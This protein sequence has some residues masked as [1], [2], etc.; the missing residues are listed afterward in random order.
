[1]TTQY[2][3]RPSRVATDKENTPVLSFPTKGLNSSLA[4]IKVMDTT[5]HSS[6]S[7]AV[8]RASKSKKSTIGSLGI[9]RAPKFVSQR[10]MS[11]KPYSRATSIQRAKKAANKACKAKNK[12]TYEKNKGKGRIARVEEE[13]GLD[14]VE[15][16][17]A[18]E[19]EKEKV[20]RERMERWRNSIWRSAVPIPA[21]RVRIPLMLPRA[22]IPPVPMI[23]T[24]TAKEV[25]PAYVYQQLRESL[26]EIEQ[27][28]SYCTQQYNIPHPDPTVPPGTTITLTLRPDHEMKHAEA[29]PSAR[30]LDPDMALCLLRKGKE[31][32]GA[33]LVV[34]VLSLV[35]ASQCAFWN[36]LIAPYTMPSRPRSG[37]SSASAV[38]EEKIE[39][40]SYS[41]GPIEETE[42]DDQSDTATTCSS[43][44]AWLS[45]GSTISSKTDSTSSETIAPVRDGKYLH[46]PYFEISV[47]SP[48]T[49]LM[50]ARHLHNPQRH[51]IIDL[52]GL[53]PPQRARLDVLDV[54]CDWSVQKLMDRL[55]VLQG[56][57][58]NI[59][60]FGIS[61]RSTWEQLAAAWACVIGVIAGHGMALKED[62]IGER[63]E[64]LRCGAEEVAW[65]YVRRV[66]AKRNGESGD[67][68][69]VG[70]SFEAAAEES[71]EESK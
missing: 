46:L 44:S 17:K 23:N 37:P 18:L 58:Q 71:T 66:R 35:W 15:N 27:I 60:C 33:L 67:S 41:L 52:L 40:D 39:P 49:F 55:G 10:R 64:K 24:N 56:F 43:D 45:T 6:L 13:K 54:I 42:E 21:D 32:D 5:L 29:D 7:G 14:A 53:P 48:E 59:V 62:Q 19:A 16:R 57:W 68:I 65:E 12:V 69:G 38:K 3:T 61:H 30:M 20:G 25:P 34:P 11:N 47:P 70:P 50:V 63:P 36:H 28:Q 9:G 4:D 22:N 31:E 1:M 26:P 2:P 51:L 8:P